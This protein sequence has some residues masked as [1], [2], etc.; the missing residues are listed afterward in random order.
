MSRKRLLDFVLRIVT[1]SFSMSK[2][3]SRH[4]VFGHTKM[5]V[6]RIVC[7]HA[8]DTSLQARK[9]KDMPPKK[10]QK[11]IANNDADVAASGWQPLC[12]SSKLHLQ[13]TLS[14]G[15]SFCW[16]PIDE[17]T[18]ARIGE[19]FSSLEAGERAVWTGTIGQFVYL[20][21]E[22]K[23]TGRILV[24]N[25]AAPVSAAASSTSSSNVK[26]VAANVGASAFSLEPL[27]R[28]LFLDEDGDSKLSPLT[29]QWSKPL[30]K[31]EKETLSATAQG[32]RLLLAQ[33]LNQDPNKILS[34]V[35]LVITDTTEMI[36]SFLCS[37]NNHL[38]RI[39]S[40]INFLAARGDPIPGSNNKF[41]FPTA[42]RIVGSLTEQQLRD[43]KFGYRAKY[44]VESAKKIV[45]EG[46]GT[47]KFVESIRNAPNVA[48]AR[49]ILMSLP[50][51]GRKVADCVLITSQ[52]Q[53]SHL[54][55]MDTHIIQITEKARG[56]G[57][58]GGG[59]STSSSL[60]ENDD[61]DDSDGGESDDD[62]KKNKQKKKKKPA[63]KPADHDLAQ[64]QFVEAF[65]QFAGFAQLIFFVSRVNSSFFVTAPAKKEAGSRRQRDDE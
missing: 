48:A 16:Q 34:R 38:S 47:E 25:G 33:T 1:E 64:Q 19:Q 52:R 60:H 43:A 12:P 31:K 42:E 17:T 18:G 4:L 35:R 39:T 46:G 32:L 40:M 49:Q 27:K 15:Q 5:I 37:Q 8:K 29:L 6:R 45:K 50:G 9:K 22:E 21:K 44:I 20:L 10:Q 57:G 14:S 63:Y 23:S 7:P 26:K 51:I 28:A 58:G 62:D 36:F 30:T 55:P 24:K 65:G 61:S 56:L 2:I 53:F 11:P 41:S 3:L 59:S 54:A 13:A